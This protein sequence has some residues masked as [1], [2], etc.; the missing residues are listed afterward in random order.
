MKSFYRFSNGSKNGWWQRY[1]LFCSVVW[2]LTVS[3]CYVMQSI[4]CRHVQLCWTMEALHKFGI[5]GRPK[6]TL[7]DMKQL[8]NISIPQNLGK[9]TLKRWNS[10][11]IIFSMSS[12][13]WNMSAFAHGLG[14]CIW[15]SV[16]LI[17]MLPPLPFCQPNYDGFP[18][19]G[20]ILWD[21]LIGRLSEIKTSS[22]ASK[23][24]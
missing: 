13:I 9:V 6:M 16:A 7:W 24:R 18:E 3:Q 4:Q 12:I 22:P 20:T 15:I 2:P 23:L 1:V 11:S 17:F 5:L 19:G 21:I 10:N 8:L 14:V